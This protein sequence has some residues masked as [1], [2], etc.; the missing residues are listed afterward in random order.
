[1]IHVHID[2]TVVEKPGINSAVSMT[3]KYQR[4]G[5]A[6]Y[7]PFHSSSGVVITIVGAT[8]RPAIAKADETIILGLRADTCPLTYRKTPAVLRVGNPREVREKIR[9]A[10]RE[11]RR[12]VSSGVNGDAYVL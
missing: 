9:V 5:L 7:L 8:G 6:K 2:L 4:H 12:C 3:I 11:F 10:I 1:M